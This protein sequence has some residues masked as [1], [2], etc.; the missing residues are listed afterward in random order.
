MRRLHP[1]AFGRWRTVGNVGEWCADRWRSGPP[2][3]SPAA[4]RRRSMA[5]PGMPTMACR[6][7]RVTPSNS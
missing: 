5:K 7:S 6:R 1:N 3:P 4:P 2:Q